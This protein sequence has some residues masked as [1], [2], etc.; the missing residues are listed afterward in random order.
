MLRCPVCS[1]TETRVLRTTERDGRVRRTRQCCQCG[2]KWATVEMTEAD[3]LRVARVESLAAD[4][5]R[6]MEAS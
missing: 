6:A 2:H 1:H 5:V 3:A 4:F